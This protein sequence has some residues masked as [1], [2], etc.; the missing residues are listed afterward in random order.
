MVHRYDCKGGSWVSNRDD[1][2]LHE[3]LEAE[4][5]RVLGAIELEAPATVRQGWV[6]YGADPT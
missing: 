4:L 3:L 5:S 1:S 6:G 2:D